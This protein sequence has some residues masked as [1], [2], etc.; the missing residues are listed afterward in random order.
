M[1]WNISLMVQPPQLG[2]VLFVG[3]FFFQAMQAAVTPS[4]L[5]KGHFQAMINFPSWFGK[6]SKRTKISRL[7]QQLH[8]HMSLQ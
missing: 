8:T 3:N 7:I 4:E 2:T 1:R 5:L 6:N